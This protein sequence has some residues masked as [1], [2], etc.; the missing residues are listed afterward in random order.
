MT[1]PQNEESMM[2][3]LLID[4]AEPVEIPGVERFE[5]TGES[6]E[7][8]KKW[9]NARWGSPLRARQMRRVPRWR[10]INPADLELTLDYDPRD[11]VHQALLAAGE[12]DV[13]FT[14]RLAV[15]DATGRP[16]IAQDADCSVLRYTVSLV[17]A[18]RDRFFEDGRSHALGVNLRLKRHG[19]FR[20]VAVGG[21]PGVR[22]SGARSQ[23]FARGGC[24]N[25]EEA[26]RCIP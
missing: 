1:T 18:T 20:D 24:R 7:A 13:R 23:Q 4:G 11:W 8:Y 19:D 2:I 22:K 15:C 10:R 6:P 3:Y 9:R 21:T 5:L 25:N 26:A 12:D 16:V 17:A 14:V